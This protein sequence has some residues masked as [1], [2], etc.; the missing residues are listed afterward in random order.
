MRSNVAAFDGLRTTVVRRVKRVHCVVLQKPLA[1][2]ARI[3]GQ[4]MP[5][6]QMFGARVWPFLPIGCCSYNQADV[7]NDGAYDANVAG[8]EV[9]RSREWCNDSGHAEMVLRE[10]RPTITTCPQIR[11]SYASLSVRLAPSPGLLFQLGSI[12]TS[13]AIPCCSVHILC[14]NMCACTVRIAALFCA[15]CFRRKCFVLHADSWYLASWS[16]GQETLLRWR[17][18]LANL[19]P[20]VTTIGYLPALALI[21]RCDALTVAAMDAL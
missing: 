15:L 21:C 11:T 17:A 16:P 6:V 7:A 9:G 20:G 19:Q 4:C 14:V 13:A 1:R 2:Q 3:R 5:S 18:R 8:R 10:A 12:A